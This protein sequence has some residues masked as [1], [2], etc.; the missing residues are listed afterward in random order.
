ML[1]SLLG[2]KLCRQL[3]C[4]FCVLVAILI[5][6]YMLPVVMGE[7]VYNGIVGIFDSIF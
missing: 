4:V 6:Y 5:A 7:G 3:A 2:P 1:Y